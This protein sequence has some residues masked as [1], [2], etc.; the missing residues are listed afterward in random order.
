MLATIDQNLVRSLIRPVLPVIVAVALVTGCQTG[1]QTGAVAGA[2][3][4]ALA[5]QAIGGDTGATLVGAAVGTGIGYMIGNEADKK[6]AQEISQQ[7]RSTD[8]S[9]TEVGPLGGTRWKIVSLEPREKVPAFASKI[10]E[11]GR[12]GHVI[13]TTTTAD[14]RVETSNEI[15]RV[16]GNTLV[17]N[18]P[19]YIVNGKYLVEGRQMIV[20]AGDFRAVLER[21]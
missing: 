10:V 19:G 4:G 11:F 16:V 8:Y 20:D 17:I 6:H 2:G 7:T 1:G 5:G 3:I 14:G 15:Y 12:D 13:T 21:L 18:R 9:H